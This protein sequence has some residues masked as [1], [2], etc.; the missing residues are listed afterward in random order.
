MLFRV[1]VASFVVHRL[2]ARE[3]APLAVEHHSRD[4]ANSSSCQRNSALSSKGA[5]RARALELVVHL[6]SFLRPASRRRLIIQP[7]NPHYAFRWSFVNPVS[8][9]NLTSN[10]CLPVYPND[11]KHLRCITP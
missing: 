6:S 9:S 7:R 4:F 11:F 8:T 2:V 5:V 10:T 1:L 3:R